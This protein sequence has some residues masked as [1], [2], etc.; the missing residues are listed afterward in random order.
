MK[1]YLTIGIDA[2]STTVKVA[3]LNAE[4]CLLYKKYSRHYADVTG[5]IAHIFREIQEQ[6]QAPLIRLA[7]TGSVGM[8]IAERCKLPFIQEVVAACGFIAKE[9]PDIKTLVDIGGEDAKMIFFRE[10]RTPDIRMNGNC[11][12]GTG[13]FI[14]Q[15]ATILNVEVSELSRLAEKASVIYPIASRCGVFSK[16]DVQNLLSRN[17]GKEDIAASVFHAVSMQVLT[18]LSRGYDVQPKVFLCGGPFHFI[19]ALQQAFIKE[20]GFS[21]EEVVLSEHAEII[22]A[23]GTALYA[24]RLPED[25]SISDFLRLLEDADRNKTMDKSKRLKPLFQDISDHHT[26]QMLKS[27]SN[28]PQILLSELSEGAC[29]VGID[30]GSTTTKIVAMDPKGRIFFHFYEKNAGNAIGT[31]SKGLSQLLFQAE[32]AGKKLQVAGSCVTGYGEDLLRKAFNIENGVVETIAHYTAACRFEPRVSFILDIGGQ[33]M[34]A[35]YIENGAIQRL[36]INEACSSGCG[37]FIETFAQGLGHSVTDFAQMAIEAKNPCDLGTRCTVFMNSKV[38]QFLREGAKVDDISAGLAY[39]VIKNCLNK[40]LKMKD[41]NEMGQYIM[42][43]GGAFRNQAL[44]RAL[45]IETGREVL[46]TNYPE[47]MGAYG[48]ALFAQ[49]Q[50][51]QKGVSLSEFVRPE[52]HTKKRS[53]C[54]GCENNCIITQFTFSN[55]NRYY[56]GNKCEKMVSNLGNRTPAGINLYTE[57][58]HLLFNRETASKEGA[59]TIGIPRALGIYE[60]YPFWHGLFTGCGFNVQLS[61]KST[62][63]LYETGIQTVMADNICFPAKIT[64][65]HV[66]NLMK[67]KVDRIFLPFVV[68]EKK[69]NQ[70]TTNS[71]NCPIVTG[72]S[73]VIRSAINPEKKAGIP[74]DSP[75]LTFKNES[76]KW[77][78]CLEY[79][80]SIPTNKVLS[81]K[82]IRVAYQAACKIQLDYETELASRSQAVLDKALRENRMV[83]LLSGRPYHSDPL[84]Q[85]KL[86]QIFAEYGA[87][88]ITEDLVR[89]DEQQPEKLQSILQWA[90]TNRILKAATIVADMPKN[91]HFVELTSFG[92]GPDAFILDEVSSILRRGGKNATFLKI[93]D[94]NNIGSMRLRI[95]S[96][97]ESLRYGSQ[98][99]SIPSNKAIHT[100]IYKKEDQQRTILIPWFADFYSP[101]LPP[102]FKLAGY[103]AINLPPSDQQSIEYGLKYSNN[104]ICYP[105]TLVIGDFMK[106][107]DSGTYDL[108]SI[109]LGISQTG[110]Q[111]RATSYT[112]LLKKALTEAGLED[113]PVVTIAVGGQANEQPGFDIP[114]RK[115]YKVLLHGI[116]YADL[117]SQMYYATAPRETVPGRADKLRA[118]F[119]SRAV[120]LIEHND[121]AGFLPLASQTA[122]AFSKALIIKEVPQIGIVGEIYVKYNCFGHKNVVNWLVQQGVET[123]LPPILNFFTA[124]FV[125]QKAHRDGNI[126]KPKRPLYVYFLAEKYVYQIV[127]S[128]EE[129]G[130]TFPYFRPFIR[131]KEMGKAATPIINLNAQF[132]EGWGISS[133]FAHFAETGINKVISLQP[134]G[135]I[136]NQVISK[137]IEKR[138]RE[139]YPNL[140]L[141]FLDFDSGM[142]EAN[143]M[144]RLH[145]MIDHTK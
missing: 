106:A 103:R 13:A 74:L 72:Y 45:E 58:Y 135:C 31:V 125:N 68:Y 76:L 118:N 109:A 55:G 86:A 92:C 97:M 22:P 87:D 30:S 85:H 84:I 88:V 136:A 131:P 6:Y 19:P 69:E 137:G 32:E 62:M 27:Q 51:N 65:G 134:F 122:E 141:L 145:F 138:T 41:V 57:K 96:L 3:V 18:S 101:L 129:R 25:Q 48:S 102:L 64:H 71:Y 117:L 38:K 61:D 52:S 75:T 98:T 130:K 20:L 29:Y 53:S 50:S 139:R 49:K 124:V 16:T 120:E 2:G 108:S 17:I 111:C 95:R 11:A 112:A 140:N 66:L 142:S 91:V 115:V 24:S 34:K 33:D 8:G 132:G 104:E 12:G 39:S 83:V 123:I 133:E 47:L 54:K 144:N 9:H 77:K 81:T 63:D 107:L 35:A 23:W 78:A 116:V 28:L 93:D 59:L 127:S 94:I 14:D 5:T 100:R 40:V 21:K 70:S 143:I 60:D 37:S 43:Q 128:I 46:V 89:F 80:Q 26:F 79:I 99:L 73:E 44:I 114:W 113:I 82:A 126:E 36:E 56:A 4:G 1:Q 119:L 15:M 67:K 10:H 110:G 42:V 90:Y 7:L 105:A 121:A